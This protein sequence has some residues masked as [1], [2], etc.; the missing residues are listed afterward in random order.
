VHLEPSV[1]IA[2]VTVHRESHV[3]I[4]FDDG[5]MCLFDLEDLRRAC[6]CAA[7]STARDGGEAWQPGGQVT[8][9]AITDAHLV[10]GYGL[11][12]IWS[13][14][15]STGIYPF[16]SLRRWCEAGRSTDGFPPDSGLPG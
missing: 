8:G 16:D 7:C 9:L 11:G 3:E 13:D 10:D 4:V 6:P 14:G 15:H 1:E 2:T 5:K 12:V